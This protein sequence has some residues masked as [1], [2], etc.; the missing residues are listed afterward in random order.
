MGEPGWEDVLPNPHAVLQRRRRM[1]RSYGVVAR[2]GD[3]LP[4]P[5]AGTF[6]N[7][8]S[9]VINDAGA[10]AFRATLNGDGETTG[11]FYASA[12]TVQ[13]VERSTGPFDLNNAGDIVFRQGGALYRWRAGTGRT[14]ILP[15]R[16]TLPSG[17]LR[18]LR[19]TPILGDGGHVALVAD[20]QRTSRSPRTAR[21]LVTIAPDG[22]V[23][24]IAV[25]RDGSPAGTS[26]DIRTNGTPISVNAGGQVAFATRIRNA[27]WGVFVYTPGAAT[28]ATIAKTGDV[29]DGTRLTDGGIRYVGIDSLGTLTFHGRFEAGGVTAGR[30]VRASGGA[31]TTLAVDEGGLFAP[32]LT[33]TGHVVWSRAGRVFLYDGAVTTVA[34]TSDVTPIGTGFVPGHPSVNDGGV[35]AFVSTREALYAF[36]AAAPAPL[37]SSGHVLPASGPIVDI[38]AHA[39]R[40]GMLAV[41]AT[42]ENRRALLLEERRGEFV[43]V[44]YSGAG[45]PAG[46]TFALD[47]DTVD[48]FG[49]G[50]VFASSID[51]GPIAYGAFRVTFDGRVETLAKN[52][53]R[54]GGRS[55]VDDV[56]AVAAYGQGAVILAGVSD[57]SGGTGIFVVTKPGRRLR[58]VAV[59][60]GRTP[61]GG[62]WDSFEAPV[63]RGNRVVF[64]ATILRGRSPSA[65]FS[66]TPRGGVVPLAVQ[67][68]RARD[69]QRMGLRRSDAMLFSPYAVA[70]G[71]VAFMGPRGENGSVAVYARRRGA[72]EA[73]LALDDHLADGDVF[74]FGDGLALVD[75]EVVVAATVGASVALLGIVP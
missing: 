3:P 64:A 30:L 17:R 16:A 25:D 67:G 62:R 43:E 8:S 23:T 2:S 11:L 45:T 21:A 73:L 71:I 14:L 54:A 44:V 65:L 26:Y 75:G 49:G 12:G 5:L 42:T 22:T 66:W 6:G 56:L 39:A 70:R 60:G 68:R 32:R 33:E 59:T 46:G 13:L 53:D 61:L 55:V 31:F 37:L 1:T 47:R 40:D 34:A 57:D 58:P 51:D 28:V 9:P 52:G 7:L 10:V 36:D 63:T 48:V 4:A 38:G 74:G 18:A 41:Y 24:V 19:G 29:V 69:R 72:P 35:T 27:G 15:A 20:L 50:A